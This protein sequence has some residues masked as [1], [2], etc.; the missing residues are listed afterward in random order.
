MTSILISK[1]V[2]TFCAIPWFKFVHLYN[3]FR[4]IYHIVKILKNHYPFDIKILI[5][6]L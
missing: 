5:L 1:S 4:I 2:L 6:Q 3:A